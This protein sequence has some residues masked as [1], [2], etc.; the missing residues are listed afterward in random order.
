VKVAKNVSRACL[1]GQAPRRVHP[2]TELLRRRYKERERTRLQKLPLLALFWDAF[3]HSESKES[4]VVGTIQFKCG[5]DVFTLKIAMVAE[6]IF[7]VH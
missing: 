1:L 4:S 6:V 3:V 7:L 2:F 5:Y